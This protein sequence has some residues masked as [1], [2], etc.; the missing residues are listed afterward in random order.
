MAR[1]RARTAIEIAGVGVEPGSRRSI[2]I[3]LP[4]FY[5]HSSVNMPLHVVH[6]RRPGPVLLV[7]AAIHGDE[8]NGVEIIRRL[9]S[10]GPLNRLKG[11]LG[12]RVNAILSAAGMNFHK[13]VRLAEDLLRQIFFCLRFYQRTWV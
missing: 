5:T 11:T 1:A 2:D 9:S 12:D 7:C 4:S 10:V 3:P 13:L 6:G 8:L